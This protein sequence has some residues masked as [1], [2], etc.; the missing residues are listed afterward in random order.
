MK[1][2]HLTAL[3][4]ATV[5]ATPAHAQVVNGNFAAGL[6]GWT[7]RGDAITSAGT[8]SIT[9]AATVDPD[10]PFNLSGN[11]AQDSEVL[12]LAANVAVAGLDLG[13]Q[14]AYEGTLVQQSFAVL[15]G[16]TLSFSWSFSSNDAQFL[17]H[18][19]VVLNGQVN[20]LA[21]SANPG[22]A[23]QVF[24]RTFAAGGPVTL[25]FGVVDTGDY[26]LVSTLKIRNVQITAVPEPATWL[27][28]ALGAGAMLLRRKSR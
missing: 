3:L 4:A 27:L 6:S 26:D 12:R 22:G 2:T 16:Q 17:D 28:M 19:F 24:S 10:T 23:S 18:A 9:T 15:A 5:L 7:V 21:S 20:T 14:T 25:S 13:D 8:L 1:L 11:S